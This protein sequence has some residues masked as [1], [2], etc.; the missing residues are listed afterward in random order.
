MLQFAPV[1]LLSLISLASQCSAAVIPP[2]QQQA[3]TAVNSL[4]ARDGEDGTLPIQR[5]AGNNEFPLAYNGSIP[6]HDP[7]II[8]HEG[9]YYLFM[10]VSFIRITRSKSLDGPWEEVGDVLDGPSIIHKGNRTLPWAPSIT[11]KGKTFYCFYS[12]SS[13]ATQNSAIGVATSDDIS[14][15][16]WVDHGLIIETGNG[17]PEHKPFKSSNAIDPDVFVDGKDGKPY[18]IYG[19]FYSGIW[20]I[21]LKEDLLSIEHPDKP[22]G[23]HLRDAH[24]IEVNQAE[25]PYMTQHGEYYYLWFS[26]GRCCDFDKKIVPTGD[27]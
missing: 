11:K 6:V 20:Q 23:T 13:T 3:E 8:R 22:T 5:T 1:F 27:E 21:P 25:G 19:S 9:Y 17:A 15:G 2:A 24:G 16:K 26:R 10:G 12:L 18:L 4:Y 7:S 14:K